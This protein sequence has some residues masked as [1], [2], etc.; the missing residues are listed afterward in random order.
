MDSMGA[1][2]DVPRA[3]EGLDDAVSVA[4]QGSS[5][6]AIRA[7]GSAVCWGGSFLGNGLAERSLTPVAVPA[8]SDPV[9]PTDLIQVDGGSSHRCALRVDDQVDCWGSDFAADFGLAPPGPVPPRSIGSA[10]AGLP[11]IELVAAA[12]THMCAVD[13]DGRVWCWGDNSFGQVGDGTVVDRITPTL[14]Y[15]PGT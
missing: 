13:F 7:N 3:V 15:D 4:V 2:S 9:P 14:V 10:T 12:E 6:C 8:G 5:A 1:D 11:P